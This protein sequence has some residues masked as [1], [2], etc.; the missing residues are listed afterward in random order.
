MIVLVTTGGTISGRVGADGTYSA[1]LSGDELVAA[2]ASSSP[3]QEISVHEFSR[4]LSFELRLDEWLGLIERLR[5]WD[6]DPAVTGVVVVM[7][8]ALL[9]EVPYLCS[10]FVRPHKPLVFT[11][12]MAPLSVPGSDATTNLLDALTVCRAANAA[13]FGPLVVMNRR[14]VRAAC[15]RKAHRTSPGAI[16]GWPSAAGEVD[17]GGVVWF[18]PPPPCPA[19]FARIALARNVPLL[20]VALGVGAEVAEALLATGPEGLVVEGFPG[21][22]G[23]PDEVAAALEPHLGSLPI[24]LS[25]RAPEGRLVRA[26]G[27]RSGGGALLARGFIGAGFLMT[28]KA[29]LLLMAAL[30]A[31]SAGANR[32][33][34]VRTAFEQRATSWM[35]GAAS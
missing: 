8:T 32:V 9:E 35:E 13:A 12:A 19:P 30:G 18:G 31:V 27:G 4:K 3:D 25:S 10:L 16:V 23:L 28:E 26:A 11:G 14:V 22:G 24:V 17:A 20:K 7:G 34:A 2:I 5:G 21:G 15:V 33:E 1:A 29:R 6:A